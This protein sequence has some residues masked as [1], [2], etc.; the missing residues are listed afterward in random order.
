MTEPCLTF[1][2]LKGSRDPSSTQE[3]LNKLCHGDA[4]PFS[5]ECWLGI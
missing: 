2:E 4:S 3:G 1:T 5:A